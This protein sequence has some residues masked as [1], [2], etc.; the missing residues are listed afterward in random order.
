MD[1]L[2][3]SRL[4]RLKLELNSLKNPV[5]LNAQYPRERKYRSEVSVNPYTFKQKAGES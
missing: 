1:Q 3:K 5:E 4:K 2:D